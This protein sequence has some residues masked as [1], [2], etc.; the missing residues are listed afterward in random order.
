MTATRLIGGFLFAR[1]K[2]AL[3][4]V[5]IT[6][7]SVA[8]E[9]AFPWLLQ[10]GIDIATGEPS[11]WTLPGVATAMMAVIVAIVIGH[12]ATLACEAHVFGQ[13]SFSLRRALYA[14][15]H[16]LPLVA[17][18]RMRTGGLAYRSTNDVTTLE[19]HIQEIAGGLL[20]DVL[21]ILATVAFMMSADIRLASLVVG[22]MAAASAVGTYFG[23]RLPVFKRAGQM[24]AARI[25]GQL[26]ESIAGARTIRAFGAEAQDLRRL[27]EANRQIQSIDVAGGLLRAMVTPLW[28]FAETVGVI[29]VLW[30]GAAL[31]Q[32]HAITIGALVG[33]LAYQQL[34]AEP[35]NRFGAYFYHLQACR[36]VARRI[37]AT[38]GAGD[39]RAIVNSAKPDPSQP[40]TLDRVSVTDDATGHVLLNE[41]TLTIAPGERIALV[42]RNGSGKSSLLDCLCALRMPSSGDV[43]L[44]T[45]QLS[46]CDPA[47]WREP[48]GLMTQDTLLFRGSL[49]FNLL[50]AKAGATQDEMRAALAAVGGS[51]LAARLGEDLAT[52][53]GGGGRALSGGERQ[54]IGLARLVL[55]DPKIALLDEPTAHLDGAALTETLNALTRF[56]ENRAM[57]VVTH[58]AEVAC[59]CDRIVVLDAG[60]VVADGPREALLASNPICRELFSSER[61]LAS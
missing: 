16:R 34:I 19:A 32:A 22:V 21:V 18:E 58:A 49:A 14:Q 4:T 7:A 48:F 33:F 31:V 59:L 35:I 20:F 38:L 47:T 13:A 42:G 17:L 36:G 40:L 43:R 57:I 60:K 6:I 54:T 39:L 5:A 41:V 61:N 9:V 15:L 56:A 10:Q 26:Q 1:P 51:R 8:V 24:R 44:G 2:M 28:H 29:A 55:R 52:E 25:A 30:Y 27:D 53:A 23:D 45:A 3:A 12:A 11:T 37:A 46:A 50:L